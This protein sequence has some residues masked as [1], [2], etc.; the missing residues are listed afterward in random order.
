MSVKGFRLSPKLNMAFNVLVLSRAPH[1][2][3]GIV[4]LDPKCMWNTN[5]GGFREG[6][7]CSDQGSGSGAE[8]M[9]FGGLEFP[10]F[11]FRHGF[12]LGFFTCHVLPGHGS[13]PTVVHEAVSGFHAWALDVVL[14]DM[15]KLP[16]TATATSRAARL[17]KS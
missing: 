2:K 16:A 4:Y 5:F 13:F 17:S 9:E 6:G 7:G 1:C 3:S 11:R 8:R 14:G 12:T 15:Q 10:L